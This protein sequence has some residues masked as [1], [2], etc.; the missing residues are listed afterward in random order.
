[1]PIISFYTR[2]YVSVHEEVYRVDVQTFV[3]VRHDD[4]SEGEFVRGFE[5]LAPYEQEILMNLISYNQLHPFK[6]MNLIG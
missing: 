2:E 1:M 4:G 5:K 3:H 6:E